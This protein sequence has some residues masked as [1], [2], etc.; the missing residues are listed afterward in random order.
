ML[1]FAYPYG[2]YNEDVMKVIRDA[3]HVYART[4]ENVD[5]P[6]PPENPMAFHPSC[7]FLAADFWQRYEK[8]KA[9]GVFYFWGH[10]YELFTE[11]IWMDFENMIKKISSDPQTKW[12]EV[13]ELFQKR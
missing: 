2:A 10:S 11:S 8:A 12:G 9:R 4:V 3:G 6:F 1:G 5:Y 7:H 13:F